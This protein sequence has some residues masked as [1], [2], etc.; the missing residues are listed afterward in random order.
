[1]ESKHPQQRHKHV[2]FVFEY[3]QQTVSHTSNT[4]V[5]YIAW[6]AQA[7]TG[8]RKC[9]PNTFV[10]YIVWRAQAPTDTRKCY[11]AFAGARTTT[12]MAVKDSLPS[13]RPRT[14]LPRPREPSMRRTT[15][16]T[17]V[18]N[19]QCEYSSITFRVEVVEQA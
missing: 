4:F 2:Q 17:K 7:P 8:T 13:L 18:P 14:L 9:Y 3:V 11:R 16:R 1:M 15:T 6:R 12:K 5:G 19:R 10:G